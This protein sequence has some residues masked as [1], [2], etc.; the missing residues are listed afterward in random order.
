MKIQLKKSNVLDGTDAREPTPAQMKYGELAVNYNADDPAIFLKDSDNAIRRIAGEGSV[1]IPD[2]DDA[3][4]QPGTLDDRYVNLTGD[5]MTGDLVLPGGGG[6]TAALQKQE[7]ETLINNSDTGA[8]KYV[9]KV[10]DSMSGNLQLP[11][12]GGNNDALQKQEIQTLI[13]NSDTGAGKYVEVAGDNMTG[14]L[15]LGGSNITLNAT[16][17]EADFGSNITVDGS[18]TF[19]ANPAGGSS[20]GARITDTGLFISSRPVSNNNIWLGYVTGNSTATSSIT[21]DGSATFSGGILTG[22][23][24]PTSGANNGALVDNSGIFIASRTSSGNNLWRGFQTGFSSTTSVINADGSAE[25]AGGD[26]ELNADGSV[27]F[28]EAQ[29]TKLVV[30][31]KTSADGHVAAAFYGAS[32]TSNR[33]LEIKLGD[34]NATSNALV[35]LDA[36]NSTNGALALAT[37]GSE[38]MRVDGDGNVGIGINLPT[39]ALDVAGRGSFTGGVKVTGGN[40]ADVVYGIYRSGTNVKIVHNGV[41]MT[42]TS[43]T[44]TDFNG[45]VNICPNSAFTNPTIKLLSSSGIGAFEGGVRVTGGTATGVSY[46]MYRAGTNVRLVHDGVDMTSTSAT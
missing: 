26:I 32:G 11:G 8:G 7:V 5:T 30:D 14:N 6:N 36:K 46:G 10:G 16:T 25:F 42:S 2:L 24:D 4:Q 44:G 41:D 28:G 17:G 1:G 38:K 43:A 13:D 3:N 9:E 20:T 27:D 45:I 21:A 37:K 12:G 23:G 31:T 18:A 19:T 39:S 35:T 40:A 33:G 15:T 22:N 34:N 29:V